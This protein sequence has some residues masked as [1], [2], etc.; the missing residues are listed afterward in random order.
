[1]VGLNNRHET[2]SYRV[3]LFNKDCARRKLSTWQEKKR[4]AQ[5]DKLWSK[6]INWVPVPGKTPDDLGYE[7]FPLFVLTVTAN[8]K[9]KNSR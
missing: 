2:L 3:E 5:N 1:M 6:L 8:D 7:E 4:Y 9:P